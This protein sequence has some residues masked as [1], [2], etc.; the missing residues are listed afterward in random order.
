MVSVGLEVE[1]PP[2]PPIKTT[3]AG[4]RCRQDSCVWTSL[5]TRGPAGGAGFQIH[6]LAPQQTAAF[7][8]EHIYQRILVACTLCL[9]SK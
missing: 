2:P 9:L 8:H 7:L 5:R 6:V 3:N 4:L 1:T